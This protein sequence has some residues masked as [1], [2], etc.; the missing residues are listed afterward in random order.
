MYHLLEEENPEINYFNQFE[1][2]DVEEK[3]FPL[4]EEITFRNSR[5][6]VKFNNWGKFLALVYFLDD[7]GVFD[8]A[9]GKKPRE[10]LLANSSSPQSLGK[11]M[12]SPRDLG[13]MHP[14]LA[15]SIGLVITNA[16]VKDIYRMNCQDY[17]L[18]ASPSSQVT[19]K[20]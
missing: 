1:E 5:Q 4:S 14:K 17:Q 6:K 10:N 8:G 2:L 19:N 15:S 16:E 3:I 9:M 11:S 18:F 7:N 13:S 12:T 20:E